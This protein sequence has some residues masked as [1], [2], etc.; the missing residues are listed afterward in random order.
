[1]RL[2]VKGL[3]AALVVLLVLGGISR[4]LDNA[5]RGSW[6]TAVVGI[7]LWCSLIAAMVRLPA[8]TE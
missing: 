2:A 1:M 3:V 5:L 7:V 6:V 4:I 8:R